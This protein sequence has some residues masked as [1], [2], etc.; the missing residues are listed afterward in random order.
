[1]RWS[2]HSHLPRKCMKLATNASPDEISAVEVYLSGTQCS[3]DNIS[4][5]L[6]GI[7]TSLNRFTTADCCIPQ[8][9]NQLNI[10]ETVHKNEHKL[11]HHST[12]STTVH[13]TVAIP[14]VAL[15]Y[16]C[17][18]LLL[19]SLPIPSTSFSITFYEFDK[20]IYKRKKLTVGK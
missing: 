9:E 11:G 3:T 20:H 1:V 18:L 10:K 13:V 14:L 4:Y 19:T 2:D 17:H 7:I 15:V 8:Q 12:A 16:S 6:M 5:H